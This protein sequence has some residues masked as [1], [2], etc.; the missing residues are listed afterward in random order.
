MGKIIKKFFE[1][2]TFFGGIF[3]YIFII[4]LLFVL[5]KNDYAYKI[6]IGLIIIYL[7]T[8]IIRIFY[9]KPRPNKEEYCNFLEKIDASSFPSVHSARAILLFLFFLGQF[10]N[11]FY[12]LL[13]SILFILIVYSRIYLKKHDLKDIVGGFIL[14]ILIFVLLFV[15]L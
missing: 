13:M 15:F 14:G 5:S 11:I 4:G 12:Y 1:E 7:A 10:K 9:F 3:F 2:I 6:T 8:F